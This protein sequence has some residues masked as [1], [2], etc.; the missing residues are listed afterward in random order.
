M[1]PIAEHNFEMMRVVILSLVVVVAIYTDIRWR[2][3]PNS[4]T[5]PTLGLGMIVQTL[6][7]GW[8]GPLLGLAGAILAPALL[9]LMHGGRGIGMGDLKLVASTGAWFG[10]ALA[11]VVTLSS[12]VAGGVL[13]LIWLA[14]SSNEL[15]RFCSV[16]LVGLPLVGRRVTSRRSPTQ[17]EPRHQALPYGIAIGIGILFALVV[18]QWPTTQILFG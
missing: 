3:V 10:P 17:S 4:L 1:N 5:F 2:R 18:A 7:F 8:T 11:L 6:T 12:A 13:A 16:F 15:G 9:L 14:R